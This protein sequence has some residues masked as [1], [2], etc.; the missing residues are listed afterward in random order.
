M[1]AASLVSVALS[2]SM[3]GL[4]AAP[5]PVVTIGAP[6][7]PNVSAE[8]WLVYDADADVVLASWNANEQAPMASVTKVMTAILVTENV[9]MTETVVVPSFVD[10][11]RGSTAGLIPGETWTVGD[12]LLGMMVRSGNDAA[13]TLGWYVGGESTST[14]VDMMNAKAREYGMT[15]TSFANPAGLDN[16]NHYSTATDLLTL[17]KEAQKHPEVVRLGRTRFVTLAEQPGRKAYSWT[18]SNK[19]LGAYPG[20]VGLKTGDTPWADKV[21]LAVTEQ[22]GRPIYSVVM[23]A[24][25]HFADTR[26]LVDWAYHTYSM[27]DRWLRPLYSEEGGGAV[28]TIPEDIS[29]TQQRRLRALPKLNDGQWNTSSAVDLPKAQQIAR[30]IQEAM[31]SVASGG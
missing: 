12:L 25:D 15:S 28:P 8:R 17:I 3:L 22:H 24:D 13:Y 30:W 2:A 23:H 16:E 11:M 29:E 20:V 18:N 26:E 27:H 1:I 31:P 14:F 4:P 10:G 7:L 6:D 5:A 9:E 21:L 19:L